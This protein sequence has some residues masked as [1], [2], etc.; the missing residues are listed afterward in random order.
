MLHF[1]S[2]GEIHHTPASKGQPSARPCRRIGG[3]C[4]NA[5]L[6]VPCAAIAGA[7]PPRHGQGDNRE[8]RCKTCAAPATV[9][10]AERP[11]PATEPRAGSGRPVSP[12]AG[13]IR[14]QARRPACPVTARCGHVHAHQAGVF[15]TQHRVL[16]C[17]GWRRALSAGRLTDPTGA[18]RACSGVCMRNLFSARPSGASLFPLLLGLGLLLGGLS[19]ARHAGAAAL[20]IV[21]DR[22]AP[23]MVARR[24]PLSGTASGCKD[25]D[26][27]CCP[28][29]RPG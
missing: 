27:Y 7:P 25:P 1:C 4:T 8:V 26:S 9:R 24:P 10:K 11:H 12:D 13:G 19:V 6:P 17:R 22:S 5:R 16:P 23:V 29:Q 3:P 14:F 28:D 21:S 15:L 20:A 18:C 2:R